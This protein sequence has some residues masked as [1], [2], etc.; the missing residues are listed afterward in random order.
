[1]F[2]H[3]VC[4]FRSHDLAGWMC[5]LEG[6]LEPIFTEDLQLLFDKAYHRFVMLLISV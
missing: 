1:M 6:M 2:L 3:E 5:S 4:V